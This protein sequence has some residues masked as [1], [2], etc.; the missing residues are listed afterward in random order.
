[1]SI[2]VLTRGVKPIDLTASLLLAYKAKKSGVEEN[3]EWIVE[4]FSDD[5]VFPELERI[6]SFFAP[7]LK[8]VVKHQQDI[9]ELYPTTKKIIESLY[10]ILESVKYEKGRI[11]IQHG[12]IVV[13]NSLGVQK[14]YRYFG[15][16]DKRRLVLYD[17]KKNYSV[18][19]LTSMESFKLYVQGSMNLYFLC[20]YGKLAHLPWYCLDT[21]I[22]SMVA[23]EI[24]FPPEG[25]SKVIFGANGMR[26]L[27][28]GYSIYGYKNS[29]STENVFSKWLMQSGS[30]VRSR[31]KQGSNCS[32][33]VLLW[34]SGDIRKEI[35]EKG[36][37]KNMED[38]CLSVS[39][40]EEN[41]IR[42]LK[43]W[44][45]SKIMIIYDRGYLNQTKLFGLVNEDGEIYKSR[46]MIL[47]ELVYSLESCC[48][49]IYP[50]RAENEYIHHLKNIEKPFG[51][52]AKY[53]F[54][55]AKDYFN[56]VFLSVYYENKASVNKIIEI[57]DSAEKVFLMFDKLLNKREGGI[58]LKVKGSI[59][60]YEEL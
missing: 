28:Y 17:N 59:F 19:D 5:Y 21:D 34:L 52:V 33:S 14:K 23:D 9:Q 12:A 13:E 53:A 1:M 60:E 25:C 2:V 15:L 16:N 44:H 4:E 51:K 11:R 26:L 10:D 3:I 35:I 40:P 30:F 38:V 39:R 20:R 55:I 36:F 6:A 46:D 37:S 41:I 8:I 54:Q 27:P 42:L 48:K 24:I 47:D 29:N 43:I 45:L 32:Q 18:L 31:N 56:Q 58:T 22:D 50:K 7:H 49:G 57:G